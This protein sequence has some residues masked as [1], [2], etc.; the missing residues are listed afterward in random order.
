M[1]ITIEKV[2]VHIY[3]TPTGPIMGS[4][5]SLH[6][7]VDIMSAELDRLTVEVAET[8]TVIDSAIVLISGLRD[9]LVAAGTD[10]VAL[11]ALA[12]SL[13][14]KQTALAA[15]VANPA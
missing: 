14:A 9:A 13:E 4:L 11:A 7:K 12:D 15:A 10:P 2:D 6:A 8:A 3:T 5:Q 1:N